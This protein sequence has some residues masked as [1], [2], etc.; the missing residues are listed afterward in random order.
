M[1]GCGL[2]IRFKNNLAVGGE[3]IRVGR[4]KI[5]HH[6]IEEFSEA[7]RS[8]KLYRDWKL[9]E[10]NGEFIISYHQLTIRI[11]AS[12]VLCIQTRPFQ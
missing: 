1:N 5:P 12:E 2:Y 3:G 7:E 6:L 4:F 9:Y 10:K 8:V 11:D